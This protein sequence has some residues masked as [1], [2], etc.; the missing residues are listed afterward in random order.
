MAQT[1]RRDAVKLAAGVAIA[2]LGATAAP[3]NNHNAKEH[4]ALVAVFRV[5]VDAKGV[6]DFRFDTTQ[7]PADQAFKSDEYHYAVLDETGV[8]VDKAFEHIPLGIHPMTLPKG[9]PQVSDYAD[10]M[11]A[12]GLQA[13]KEYYL[14]VMVRNLTALAKF[15]AP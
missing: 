9:Q 14:V 2:G 7:A 11:I 1:T 6:I 4:P 8:Q 3:G 12:K 13:G 15:K 5:A 10:F